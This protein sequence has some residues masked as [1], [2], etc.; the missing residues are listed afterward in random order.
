MSKFRRRQ[1]QKPN[2]LY[3]HSINPTCFWCGIETEMQKRDTYNPRACTVEHLIPL[4]K[5][6][7][8]DIRNAVTACARCNNNRGNDMSPW[9][10][11]R[12]MQAFGWSPQ[13]LWAR[14]PDILAISGT[15]P[16]DIAG[17]VA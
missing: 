2:W 13:P 7:R 3:L 8:D 15:I 9:R 16:A 14:N 11:E 5:G 17:S 4:S 6:G 1:N 12:I 10:M